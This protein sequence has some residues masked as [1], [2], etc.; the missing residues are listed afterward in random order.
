[1]RVACICMQKNERHLLGPWL[2]YHE[3]LFGP[4]S[5][6]VFDNGSTDESAISMLKAAEARSV[7]VHWEYNTARDYEKKHIYIGKLIEDM[8]SEF[9][10]LM[11]L[12]CDEF[13]AH[14]S[15][16]SPGLRAMAA[17]QKLDVSM[18]CDDLGWHFANWHT[19]HIPMGETAWERPKA[20]RRSG[21]RTCR[22]FT[23]APIGRK[24]WNLRSSAML[25]PKKR[26]AWSSTTS[27]TGGS[28]GRPRCLLFRRSGR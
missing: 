25:E 15:D 28:K 21:A 2:A 17:T 24:A 13:V 7:S 23:R 9:D 1:M 18:V 10:F 3:H 26:P 27:A 5:I 22:L 4:K 14:L 16:L 20:S 11:P 12:D 19:P 8:A 6:V